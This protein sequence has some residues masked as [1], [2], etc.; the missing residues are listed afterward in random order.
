MISVC[1]VNNWMKCVYTLRT[2]RHKR[3]ADIT[4]LFQY[5]LKYIAFQRR[6]F[7]KIL[8]YYKTCL[9]Y[10]IY[11]RKH[12]CLSACCVKFNSHSVAWWTVQCK[13]NTVYQPW[14]IAEISPRPY[15]QPT[16]QYDLPV[17]HPHAFLKKW[18][19]HCYRLCPS[20]CYAISS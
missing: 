10:T 4:L 20:V 16:I 7:L 5:I 8:D 18:R 19:G 15:R 6:H 12:N 14:A 1:N 2:G 3:Q 11:G 13:I 17:G 9:P